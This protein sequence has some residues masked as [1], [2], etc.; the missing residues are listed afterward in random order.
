MSPTGHSYKPEG[1]ECQHQSI[2]VWMGKE[3]LM[4]EMN[5]ADS[6]DLTLYQSVETK[7]E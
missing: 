6:I 3:G 5:M 7:Q 2:K 1:K 4:T